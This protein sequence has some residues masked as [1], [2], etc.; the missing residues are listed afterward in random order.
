MVLPGSLSGFVPSLNIRSTRRRSYYHAYFLLSKVPLL[1][2]SSVLPDLYLLLANCS[3]VL[4]YF[5]KNNL[6]SSSDKRGHLA[7][8]AAKFRNLPLLKYLHACGCKWTSVVYTYAAKNADTE[9]LEF[10]LANGCPR[11][12]DGLLPS[13]RRP[14]DEGAGATDAAAAQGNFALVKWLHSQ[15][16][17][18][19]TVP[20]HAAQWGNLEMLQWSLRMVNQPLHTYDVDFD[21][22]PLAAG[23]GDLATLEWLSA[24]GC[25]RNHNTSKRI[26]Y[27]LDMVVQ[28]SFHG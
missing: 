1:F 4:F 26:V 9:M 6:L 16:F 25:P 5:N 3:E 10:A 21:L 12:E 22:L 19:R 14:E 24:N 15:G 23:S 2:C 27:L 18:I 17:S 7:S 13:A 8:S 20:R 11:H 28:V